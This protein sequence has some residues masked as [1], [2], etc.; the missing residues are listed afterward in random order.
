MFF[1]I[2]KTTP[3]KKLMDAYCARQG[4]NTG[5]VRFSFDGER[6]IGKETPEQLG[7]NDQDIID[8]HIEQTGG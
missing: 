3:M 4:L 7:M 8:C 1:K 5:S 2:K 6:L